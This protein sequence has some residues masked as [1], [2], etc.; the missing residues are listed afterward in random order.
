MTI[1]TDALQGERHQ[2][3]IP[4]PSPAQA[5][6]GSLSS[7]VRTERGRARVGAIPL[8]REEIETDVLV[9]GGGLAGLWAAIRAR[10]QG[11]R[12]LVV[13]KGFSGAAGVSVFAGAVV[14]A[15]TPEDDLAAFMAEQVEDADYLLDPDWAELVIRE[16]YERLQEIV[17][18]GGP[19]PLDESGQL[20]R[21]KAP[22]HSRQT[23]WRVSFDSAALM[24]FMR[25]VAVGRSKVK[26]LDQAVVTG[27]LVEDG[28]VAGAVALRRQEERVSVIRAGAVVLA[29]GGCSWKG[30]HFGQDMVCGEAYRLA[31]NAGA[32]LMSME[33]ANGYLSTFRHADTHSQCLL[34]AM[35][36]TFVNK[37]G[38]S[39]LHR[40]SPRDPAP[41]HLIPRAMASEVRA[42]RGPIRFDLTGIPKEAQEHWK[43]TF[44]LIWRGMERSGIDAFAQPEEWF[45]GFN[46]SVSGSAG[47]RLVDA[48]GATAG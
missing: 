31:W 28:R 44:P 38:K 41:S 11:K 46:G 19:L 23:V 34:A 21:R 32:D 17:A 12:V 26:A 9:I 45:P 36:G 15:L 43:Q 10:E 4:F 3:P 42:G 20:V 1:G 24:K 6:E 29:A 39:F 25:Q 16:S 47:V 40:Y 22:V 7:P 30:T 27:L 18:W 5:R 13:E 48:S 14:V 2:A 35:G 33:F 8:A 37:D